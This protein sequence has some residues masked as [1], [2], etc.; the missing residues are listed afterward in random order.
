MTDPHNSTTV[1]R[2]S[3][4]SIGNETVSMHRG[5]AYVRRGRRSLPSD[6]LATIARRQQRPLAGL[7]WQHV[8]NGDGDLRR[9]RAPS[10]VREIESLITYRDRATAESLQRPLA[11]NPDELDAIVDACHQ[12]LIPIVSLTAMSGLTLPISIST[13]RAEIPRP[14]SV[15]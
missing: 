8:G 7:C 12:K 6:N 15:L 2:F 14:A 3:L 11:S 1:K 10:I 5:I 4:T 9:T 13:V